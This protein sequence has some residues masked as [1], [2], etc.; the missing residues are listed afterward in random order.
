MMTTPHINP[1]TIVR[2][3][4]FL[5]SSVVEGATDIKPIRIR[6]VTEKRRL[7]SYYSWGGERH[8]LQIHGRKA[9]RLLL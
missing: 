6:Q 2:E 9:G 7:P 5:D 3:S 1:R 4:V 8:S